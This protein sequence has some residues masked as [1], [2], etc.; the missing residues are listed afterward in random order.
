MKVL[1]CRRKR[2]GSTARSSALAGESG[3]RRRQVRLRSTLRGGGRA[4]C[5]GERRRVASWCSGATGGR[6]ERWSG[7]C[8]RRV[9]VAAGGYSQTDSH[10]HSCQSIIRR[11]RARRYSQGILS[12]L[13]L[14]GLSRRNGRSQLLWRGPC[15]STGNTTTA[16]CFACW[17]GSATSMVVS[18]RIGCLEGVS[19][20]STGEEGRRTKAAPRGVVHGLDALPDQ[21]ASAAGADTRSCRVGLHRLSVTPISSPEF[22]GVGIGVGGRSS[23]ADTPSRC[24]G[25]APIVAVV[26]AA[27]GRCAPF[28]SN[29][30]ITITV[31]MA[32]IRTR[33]RGLGTTALAAALALPGFATHG[34]ENTEAP[35]RHEAGNQARAARGG[36]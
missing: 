24:R 26:V 32:P 36:A 35:Q 7:S 11:G 22:T 4:A 18:P 33:V 3:R 15:C 13:A 12:P 20:R 9:G 29:S 28:G 27:V 10:G 16:S 23:S 17:S 2:C 14:S 34:D 21:L 31:T 25:S 19:S 1:G 8:G 30:L 6:C 5:C